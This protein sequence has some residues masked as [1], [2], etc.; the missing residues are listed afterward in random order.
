MNLRRS[1]GRNALSLFCLYFLSS[2]SVVLA[3]DSLAA[4]RKQVADLLA[5][6]RFDEAHGAVVKALKLYPREPWL[7]AQAAQICV[8]LERDEEA[9]LFAES[10]E[11]AMQAKPWDAETSYWLANVFRQ[12][13]AYDKSIQVLETGLMDFPGNRSLRFLLGENYL[14]RGEPAKSEA[15]FQPLCRES[16]SSFMNWLNLMDAQEKQ[17]KWQS[18]V[19]SGKLMEKAAAAVPV[20]AGKPAVRDSVIF[21]RCLSHQAKG[22][23]KLGRWQEAKT[24][25][26]RVL[27]I[28][29][30]DRPTLVDHM[31]VCAKLNDK[32][33][34]SVDRKKLSE[35]DK[36]L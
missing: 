10:A 7:L 1:A 21:A 22:Y 28:M 13:D 5:A 26:E 11:R 17:G 23:M 15:I 4:C 24:C 12:L 9:N 33:G 36:G 14:R 18:L 30:L 31:M 6:K 20:T 32:V 2:S 3:G 8:Y 25:L 16:P 29:P 27:R 35:F 19:E 34:E